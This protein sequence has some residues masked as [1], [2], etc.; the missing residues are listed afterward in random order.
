M[1]HPTHLT[2]LDLCQHSYR[3]RKCIGQ[4]LMIDFSKLR[5]SGALDQ[6]QMRNNITIELEKTEDFIKNNWYTNFINIFMDKQR[7][8]NIPSTQ[9][10][11]FYS[12]VAV[13]ISN[14][15]RFCSF[16]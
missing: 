8:K 4:M 5:A 6:H 14:Q 7:L 3:D 12:S 13:L 16:C 10:E 11:S 15:V 9:I 1:L 2:V